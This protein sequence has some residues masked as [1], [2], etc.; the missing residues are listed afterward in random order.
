[1]EN[2]WVGLLDCNN[3]F[4]SCERLFRP[5]LVGKPVAVLS[6]NDGC[7]VAR[8]QE[9]KDMNVPMGVPYFQIKDILKKGSVTTFSSH[10]SLYRDI[11]RRVFEV[12]KR[13]MG[14]VEQYSIDEAFFI[15]KGSFAEVEN[16]IEQLKNVIE[17]EVGIPVS[18]GLAHSKTQAKYAASMAKKSAGVKVLNMEE[19]STIITDIP[20]AKIWGVGGQMELK[21]KANGLVTVA[22]YLASDKQRL[23]AIFGV[24]GQRLYAVLS[25]Y[26]SPSL[27]SSSSAQKSL[28][29]S[30][31]FKNPTENI[32]VLADAIAYHVRHVAADLRRLKLK[33]SLI[34][35]SINTSRHGDFILRGGTLDVAFND[36]TNDTFKLM[37]AAQKLLKQL[38]ENDVPYKKV[39]VVVSDLVDSNGQQGSLFVEE[40][41]TR[42]QD[43][44]MEIIDNL[45]TGKNK[46]LVKLGTRLRAKEW[47]GRQDSCSPSYTTRWSDVARVSAK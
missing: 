41:V 5:D 8:S 40:E 22:D 27:G 34:R 23:G 44:L 7:V 19:W 17:M 46:N 32:D 24:V 45:N 4:V 35:V 16:M 2:T 18:I 15:C 38:Y 26:A 31:S 3:F 39:G 47:Q 33:A 13:E 11:S 20:L 36:S 43:R 6:S 1:M 42:K 25:G 12:M 10:I 21:Y 9:V 28:M 30:R 14:Q 37:A 29:S